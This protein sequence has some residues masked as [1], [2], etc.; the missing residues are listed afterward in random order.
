MPA[1]RG[2]ISLEKCLDSIKDLSAQTMSS[3]QLHDRL[4]LVLTNPTQTFTTNVNSGS[5]GIMQNYGSGSNNT[6]NAG[7]NITIGKE[8]IDDEIRDA[9]WVVDPQSHKADIEERQGGLIK[10]SYRW[11]L[12]H[13]HFKQWYK[14]DYPLLW[15]NGD[16]GKGKTMCMCGIINHINLQSKRENSGLSPILSYFFCDASYPTFNNATSVLR[17]IIGSIIFQDSMALS[18]IRRRFKEFSKPLLDPRIAWPVLKKILVGILGA[19][20]AKKTYLIIDALDECRDD[21]DKLL[22]LIANQPYMPHVKWLVSSRKWSDIKEVLRRRPRLLGLSLEDN[23]VAVSAAV[24]L[25][26]THKVEDLCTMKEYDKNERVA[27][28]SHLRSK[29]NNTFLWVSLVCKMLIRTP[30]DLTM[31]MLESFPSGLDALYRRMLEQIRPS[32]E[33][34]SDPSFGKLYEK[35]VSF[36]LSAFRPLSLD[37]LCC[38]IGDDKITV[39]RFQVTPPRYARPGI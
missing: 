34:G 30:A 3:D 39:R 13:G 16:P 38:L 19:N 32:S 23:E 33:H 9:F 1:S 29:A 10:R 26:I 14:E 11:I 21:R 12:Q 4:S 18:Y 20:K 17:G 27:V 37:E 15:L 5:G 25:Y 24:D 2:D 6:Y 28:E 36:A 22:D 7:G 35:I 31:M 8:D